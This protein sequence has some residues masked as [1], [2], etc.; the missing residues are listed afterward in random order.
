VGEARKDRAREGQGGDLQQQRP[1]FGV[2]L[3][4]AFTCQTLAQLQEV[5]DVTV[6]QAQLWQD[7]RQPDEELG[8]APA[9]AVV[10]VA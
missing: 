1:T 2:M 9:E 4:R 10:C 6:S 7:A 3:S 5:H 8:G